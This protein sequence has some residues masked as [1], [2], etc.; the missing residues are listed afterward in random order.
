METSQVLQEKHQI[1][2]N[3]NNVSKSVTNS[4]KFHQEVKIVKPLNKDI[5]APVVLNDQ[6]FYCLQTTPFVLWGSLKKDLFR[7]ITMQK[8]FEMILTSHKCRI[9]TGNY[10]KP[11]ISGIKNLSKL[12]L[13]NIY[14]ICVW[15]QD[16]RPVGKLFDTKKGFPLWFL[17]TFPEMVYFQSKCLKPFQNGCVIYF[18]FVFTHHEIQKLDGIV[19]KQKYAYRQ[20]RT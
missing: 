16:F 20:L 9:L 17:D 18:N 15:Q 3:D 2:K 12:L 11:G 13:S 4:Q 19:T 7:D 6:T 5:F 10:K 14:E 1:V 8:K